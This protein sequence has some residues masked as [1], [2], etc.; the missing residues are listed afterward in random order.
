V[1]MQ[2][3]LNRRKVSLARRRWRNPAIQGYKMT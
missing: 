3:R 2:G 1:K